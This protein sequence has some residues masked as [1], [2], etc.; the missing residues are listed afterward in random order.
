MDRNK[1]TI[2]KH[3][4][5]EMPWHLYA[6][7]RVQPVFMS[8][9]FEDCVIYLKWRMMNRSRSIKNRPMSAEYLDVAHRNHH[10]IQGK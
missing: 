9:T 10:D 5:Y 8:R 6:P 2:R 1:Y 4:E 3:E 7:F